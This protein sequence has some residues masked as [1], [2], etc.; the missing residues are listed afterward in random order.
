MRWFLLLSCLYLTAG[1]GDRLV[2]QADSSEAVAAANVSISVKSFFLSS[3]PPL[4]PA[5][6]RCFLVQFIVDELRKMSDS[7]IYDTLRLVRI[8]KAEKQVIYTPI[9]SHLLAHKTD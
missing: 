7:G 3:P 5:I 8:V 2:L 4:L 1:L 6:N 9:P